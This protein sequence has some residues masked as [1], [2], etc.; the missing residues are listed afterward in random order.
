[1][2]ALRFACQSHGCGRFPLVSASGTLVTGCRHPAIAS[3][4]G[5]QYPTFHSR[6]ISLLLHLVGAVWSSQVGSIVS[7]S[8]TAVTALRIARRRPCLAAR[9]AAHDDPG[10]QPII[11]AKNRPCGDNGNTSAA[12][13]GL[14]ST[15][16]SPPQPL[17]RFLVTWLP[18]TPAALRFDGVVLSRATGTGRWDWG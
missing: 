4:K 7:C 13:E 14:A 8:L 5:G 17:A 6:T 10:T 1:M 3:V 12:R 16:F 15:R 11:M 2:S 18:H 9:M